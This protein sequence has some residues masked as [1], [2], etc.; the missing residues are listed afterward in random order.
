LPLKIGRLLAA[1]PRLHRIEGT[2]RQAAKTAVFEAGGDDGDAGGELRQRLPEMQGI[3]FTRFGAGGTYIHRACLYLSAIMPKNA[4]MQ[5]GLIC[6]TVSFMK[7]I[8]AQG[9]V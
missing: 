4:R 6:V 9:A 5:S 1:V 3:E 7:A 2:G 8:S